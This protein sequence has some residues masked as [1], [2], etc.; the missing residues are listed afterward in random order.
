MR[1]YRYLLGIFV[2]VSTG[3]VTLWGDTAVLSTAHRMF[4]A[5]AVLRDALNDTQRN[6]AE[7]EFK[8]E[9]RFNFHYVP[10]ARRGLPFTEMN[11]AER[12]LAHGLLASGLSDRGYRKALR[13][14]SLDEILRIMERDDGSRRNPDKYYFSFFGEPSL[15]GIWGWRVEGHHLSLNYT[16]KDG[17][18]VSVTP[19]FFGANPH[20]VRQGPR[21]GLRVLSS[22]EDLARALLLSLSPGK[23][24]QAIVSDTAPRDILTAAN[25]KAA[26]EGHA[27]GISAREMNEKEKDLLW[28]IV[29]EYVQNMPPD[30]AGRELDDIRDSGVENLTFTWEGPPEQ[31]EK[32]YYR[33]QGPTFLIEYD[34]TQNNG[35]H[36]HTVWRKFDNDFGR[37]ALAEHYKHGHHTH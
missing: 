30:I 17:N 7:I 36:S 22:E 18:V 6:K 16:I 35:N 15:S 11:P 34:N 21:S 10:R 9:E 32:H 33:I 24:E 1:T 37:D 19:A 26:I 29:E 27:T 23:R 2:F 13:I 25:R 3:A 5:A 14:M 12:H 28:Q 31:G 20:E 8:N 4:D